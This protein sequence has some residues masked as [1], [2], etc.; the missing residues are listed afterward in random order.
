MFR[1][2]QE[3]IALTSDVEAMFHQVR[4]DPKDC[5]ALRFLWW[6]DADF[7]KPPE[8]YQMQVHLFGATSSP[9]CSSYALKKTAHDHEAEFDEE[10]IKTVDKNFYVDDCLK[11]VSTTNK[12][13]NLA[14]QLTALLAKGGFHLT[15]WMSNSREVL[16]TIPLEERAPSMI[17]IDFESLPVERALGVLWDVEADAFRFRIAEMKFINTRRGIL[18]LVSSMYDPFGFASPI[19]L[20]AKQVLQRLCQAKY[21][22]DEILPE[23]EL[24]KICQTIFVVLN[25]TIFRTRLEMVTVL[26][27]ICDK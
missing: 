26:C 27:L 23:D 20:P 25:F 14:N 11:S 7:T 2:P 15:K 1:F 16:A 19:V 10:T 18:S 24:N 4:V 6:P 5:N 3:R 21:E 12:A 9:S 17:Y 8:E 13:V 22:W